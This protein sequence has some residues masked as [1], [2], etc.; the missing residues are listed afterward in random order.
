MLDPHSKARIPYSNSRRY[1]KCAYFKTNAAKFCGKL[2]F[3]TAMG[4]LRP[5]DRPN[6]AIGAGVAPR[7]NMDANNSKRNTNI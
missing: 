4:L 3:E 7:P 5:F 2:D 1:C 6:P